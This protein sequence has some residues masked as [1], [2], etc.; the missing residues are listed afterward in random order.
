MNVLSEDVTKEVVRR[1][2]L[3]VLLISWILQGCSE[4]TK[5]QQS[6]PIVTIEQPT[7]TT[8]ESGLAA[9]K[10]KVIAKQGSN[11]WSP[12]SLLLKMCQDSEGK[13]ELSNVLL[14]P[15]ATSDGSTYETTFPKP[16][17]PGSYYIICQL[18]EGDSPARG[19][20]VALRR[21]GNQS[22][23]FEVKKS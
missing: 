12:G 6:D 18:Q 14:D 17:T 1:A 21:G 11:I 8:T 20:S 16:R 23:K 5:P 22:L 9:L 10:I 13:R 19:Q 4:D 15:R 3:S 2:M 7:E